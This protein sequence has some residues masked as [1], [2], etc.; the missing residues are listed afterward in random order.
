MTQVMVR[1]IHDRAAQEPE[2]FGMLL[3]HVRRGWGRRIVSVDDFEPFDPSALHGTPKPPHGTE[4]NVVGLYRRRPGDQLRLDPLDASLI[5][6]SFTH[7]GMVY[8]LIAPGA[9]DRA[10]FFTE[11]R[12]EVHGYENDGEFPFDAG[13]LQ[14]PALDRAP[15]RRRRWIP[16]AGFVACFLAL[17]GWFFWHRQSASPPVLPAVAEKAAEMQAQPAVRPP[18]VESPKPVRRPSV[19]KLR[20][21]PSSHH[22]RPHLVS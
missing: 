12:G 5:Q 18:I 6:T 20:K 14:R 3:G 19:K 13:F 1:W 9:P 22:K 8:L 17:A 16:A 10:S 7:P 2:L 4:L 21:R 11:E 15:V